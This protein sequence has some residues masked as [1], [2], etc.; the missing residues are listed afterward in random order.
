[1]I[2]E[3][4]PSEENFVTPIIFTVICADSDLSI[5]LFKTRETSGPEIDLVLIIPT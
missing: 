3:K 1:M 4:T 2:A 5:L